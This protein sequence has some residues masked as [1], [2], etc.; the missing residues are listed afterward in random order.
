[1]EILIQ[2]YYWCQ[3]LK[4]DAHAKMHFAVF[5]TTW[6]FWSFGGI[7][8]YIIIRFAELT[9]VSWLIYLYE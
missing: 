6:T 8:D 5:C 3:K 7:T 9:P 2:T 1:M 4:R